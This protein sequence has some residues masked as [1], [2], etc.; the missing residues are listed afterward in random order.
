MDGILIVNKPAGL[1]SHD[2][3]DFI[4][5][6][7]RIKKAGHAGTL[8]PLATGVL[9]ILLNKSTKLSSRIMNDAKEYEVTLKLGVSTDSGDA[10]GRILSKS[11]K[12]NVER[13]RL[14]AAIEGFL[15]DVEQI[16]PM[17]SALKY[18]GKRLYQLARKGIE[19]P[20]KPRLIHIFKIEI[21]EFNL[22]FIGLRVLC[23]KGT[24]IRTL[25]S[26]IG[27]VLGCGA[28]AERMRRIRSGDY[29]IQDSLTFDELRKMSREDLEKRVLAPS[30][31]S[32]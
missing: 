1:T 15:G 14:Q 6:R 10:D 21:I 2:V 28:Y 18:K 16:P 30:K 4:R 17:V 7:F 32:L 3:V 29:H 31:I 5:K 26:E 25:C 20:R 9:I 27:Q 22:P 11:N 8:D 13:K 12:T 23:S 19:V 24:Y